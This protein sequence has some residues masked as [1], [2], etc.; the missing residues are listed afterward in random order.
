MKDKTKGTTRDD[1][2]I[3]PSGVTLSGA[4]TQKDTQ[5]VISSGIAP[6]TP[7]SQIISSGMSTPGSEIVLNDEKYKII[8]VI[9]KSTGEAEVYLVEKKNQKQIG[10]AHV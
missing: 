3:T 9:A 5:P 8:K 10:R 7:P 1:G 2:S 6:G 4:G